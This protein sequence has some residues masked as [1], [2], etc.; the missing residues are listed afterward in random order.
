MWCIRLY[1]NIFSLLAFA[2]SS[3]FTSFTMGLFTLISIFC[4]RRHM[5][6]ALSPYNIIQRTISTG[7]LMVWWTPVCTISS[8]SWH[9]RSYCLFLWTFVNHLALFPFSWTKLSVQDR[10]AFFRIQ[11]KWNP[12]KNLENKIHPVIPIWNYIMDSFID[13]YLSVSIPFLWVGNNRSM[14]VQ[15]AS[16]V[17]SR[18]LFRFNDSILFNFR[19]NVSFFL[20]YSWSYDCIMSITKWCIFVS[21][22]NFQ[23]VSWTEWSIFALR[24]RDRP[25]AEKKIMAN[26]SNWHL[27]HFNACFK[28]FSA[29]FFFSSLTICH[30][31]LPSLYIVCN[32]NVETLKITPKNYSFWYSKK[33]RVTIAR[34]EKKRISKW[35]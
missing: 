19:I 33:K 13:I 26:I 30:T 2:F 27:R 18:L 8:I 17:L 23:P 31:K 34:S 12:I 22:W 7:D 35:I 6:F 28:S 10:M 21:S 24:R 14:T 25:T 20:H 16:I 11:C 32:S 5:L 4:G 29:S 15:C 9:K 1:N 3:C